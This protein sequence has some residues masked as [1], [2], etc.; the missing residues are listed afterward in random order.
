MPCTNSSAYIIFPP[1]LLVFFF[2][3]TA[4]TEIYT[5]SLHDALPICVARATVT[6][7]PTS[8]PPTRPG[9]STTSR[10]EEHTSEL[11]SPMYLVC[12]LLLEK[13]RGIADKAMR[14]LMDPG[15]V[16]R[17][18]SFLTLGVRPNS[19]SQMT[20]VLSS[21]L[22]FLMIRRPPRSTLFPY[23]TLFRSLVVR[24]VLAGE[25]LL[26]VRDEDET[27][28]TR[29]AGQC[30]GLRGVVGVGGV[31]DL[32]H[33]RQFLPVAVAKGQRAGLRGEGLECV[34]AGADGVLDGVGRRVRD[35]GPDVLRHDDRLQDLHLVDEL[36]A[37]EA[38]GHGVAG[39]ADVLERERVDVQRLVVA[40]QLERVR[41]V[42]AGHRRAV[43]KLDVVPDGQDQ[44]LE[45]VRPV[46]L[47]RQ[48]R[49]SLVGGLDAVVHHE[50]LVDE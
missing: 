27:P 21:I 20:S 15:Q 48:P 30:R 22:F 41:D 40:E 44:L 19:P 14:T 29:A 38:E 43:G 33:L 8:P 49:L 46:P 25:D 36:R 7:S 3:D 13:K 2:N 39:R 28:V 16:F 34:R 24:G 9:T 17:P 45:V 35:G 18:A 12:R 47:R 1:P 42:V 10:S 50:G 37:V 11:Q 5:L 26:V 23:T 31:V 4:T 32:L 6:C